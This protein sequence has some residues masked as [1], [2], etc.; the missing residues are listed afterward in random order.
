ML[1]RKSFIICSVFFLL[2]ACTNSKEASDELKK[3]AKEEIKKEGIEKLGNSEVKEILKTNLDLLFETLT[4]MG[5]ENNWNISANPAEY[6]KIKP[7]ILP[8]VTEEFADSTIKKL[9]KEYYCECDISFKPEI[10]YDV[11]FNY[12]QIKG[13]KVNVKALAPASVLSPIGVIWEFEIIKE[14]GWKINNWSYQSLEG[15]DIELSKEEAAI[16]LSKNGKAP[17]FVKEYDSKAALGKAFL[18]RNDTQKD[19]SLIAISSKDTKLVY[20][21]EDNNSNND[22]SV[23]DSIKME[24]IDKLSQLESKETHREYINDLQVI[25]DHGFN[26]Q[27]WDDALNEIYGILKTQLTE[28]EMNELRSKQRQWI[29]DRDETAQKRYDEEGGG[30]LSRLVKAATLVQLTKDRCYELVN[31]YMK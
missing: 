18:F 13:N 7:E 11:R 21:F 30:T 17:E 15:L 20:D 27:L 29:K 28:S 9:S 3:E 31:L 12:E 16:L 22:A 2:T 23:V 8:Y 10:N 26:Y 1:L 24:Y 25:Q 6:D 5:S 19:A 4:N 14:D